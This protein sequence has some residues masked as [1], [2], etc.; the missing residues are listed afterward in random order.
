MIT[1]TS[2]TRKGYKSF[3]LYN[4]DAVVDNL[5]E[6]HS[7]LFDG[8]QEYPLLAKDV[9]FPLYNAHAC[10]SIGKLL[11][12]IRMHNRGTLRGNLNEIHSRL[13]DGLQEYP[14]PAKDVIFPLYNAHACLSIG[15]LLRQI[16]MHNRGTLRGNLNEIH[17]KLFDGLQEYPFY[18][19]DVILS[20][21]NAHACLSIGKLY[22]K[23]ECTTGVFS[24]GIL[25]KFIANYLMDY[26][27]IPFMQ[28]T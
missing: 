13:F 12:Q 28:R 21:Y 19:K 26:R 22:V 2:L 27:N 5:N 4:R 6:I 10:L 15:K 17:S 3:E 14:L 8:L 24:E 25:M 1:K 23:L 16:R 18:A 7:R 20:L 11:R 9:I